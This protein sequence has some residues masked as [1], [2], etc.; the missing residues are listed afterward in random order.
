[1]RGFRFDWTCPFCAYDLSS[2]VEG[3]QA[4]CP[5][6]GRLWTKAT[7]REIKNTVQRPTG[8]RLWLPLLT[9]VIIGV[10]WIGFGQ[11]ELGTALAAAWSLGCAAAILGQ[12]VRPRLGDFAPTAGAFLGAPF[13]AAWTW[14][15][16]AVVDFVQRLL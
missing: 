13:A 14:A 10:A 6:C 2:I 5:E 8:L 16:W 1:M 15:C 3:G 4:R 11:M 7:L 9:P 12:A